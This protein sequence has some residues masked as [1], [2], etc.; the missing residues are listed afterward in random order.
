M[1]MRPEDFKGGNHKTVADISV[2]PH[3][4]IALRALGK[5]PA[6]PADIGD[7]LAAMQELAPLARTGIGAYNGIT[8]LFTQLTGAPEHSVRVEAA[9]L[10]RSV[11][12]NNLI[13]TA[14]L[15]GQIAPSAEAAADRALLEPHQNSG[16][17]VLCPDGRAGFSSLFTFKYHRGTSADTEQAASDAIGSVARHPVRQAAARALSYIAQNHPDGRVRDTASFSASMVRQLDGTP[18]PAEPLNAGQMHLGKPIGRASKG[19]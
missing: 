16:H 2:C 3:G 14:R 4:R 10:L 17:L 15:S 9:K 18:E 5:D 6:A 11:A 1:L 8:A 19:A 12:A 13:S 7:R